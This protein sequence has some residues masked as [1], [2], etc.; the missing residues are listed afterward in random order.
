VGLIKKYIYFSALL[1]SVAAPAHAKLTLDERPAAKLIVEEKLTPATDKTF[2]YC[3]ESNPTTFSPQVAYD[4]ST[5]TVVRSVFNRL[6]DFEQGSTKVIPSLAKSW[7]MSGDGREITFTLRR[8][9]FFHSMG[10]FSPTRPLNADDVIYTF[11]RMRNPNHPLHKLGGGNYQYFAAIEMDKII[12]SIVKVD[13]YK[14]K[15]VL[16]RP[17]APILAN[18]GMD[19]AS[20]I[21]QEY[22]EHLIQKK[23][24][25]VF[26]KKPVGTGPFVFVS[27]EKN[28]SVELRRN[29]RYFL[30]PAK[31]SSLRFLIFTNAEDRS[32]NLVSGVCHLVANP[33]YED[34]KALKENSDL[35]VV[36]QPG[37]NIFYIAF[38]VNREPFK[39]L[40]V[41]QAIN[42]ALNKSRYIQAGFQGFAQVAKNPIPPNM[43]GF[44]KNI[45]DFDYNPAKAK[46][47]LKKAGFPNG[48]ST[49]YDYMSESRPYNPNGLKVAELM[50]QDLAQVGIT[51]KLVTYPWTEY[52]QKAQKREFDML[53]MGWTGDNGDPDNFL[54]VLLSCAGVEGGTNYAGWCDKKF[55]FLVGRARVTTN[56]VQRTRFYEQ[57]Q[58]LFREQ[59]PWAPIAHT[60]VFR[61]MKKNVS[62]YRMSP[63]GV[64]TFHSV[65]IK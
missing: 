6:V 14:V 42:H 27:F 12:K 53:Q 23:N 61:A 58:V 39:K 37:L 20:I 17:E 4:T 60:T 57:A 55:S 19:F 65:D 51:V 40:E 1:S 33:R 31:V 21:S 49:T 34:V 28:K 45:Q 2:V 41:R 48:F 52:L 11:E 9:V 25:Q 64:D 35:K 26:D 62:G 30:G 18:L 13:A 43:W 38:N 22:A 36:S 3:S 56:I 10:E 24:I 50:V 32:K 7:A 47:L 29:E 44:N 5:F 54:N 15:F 46:Q 16:D 59:S 8:D 63:F